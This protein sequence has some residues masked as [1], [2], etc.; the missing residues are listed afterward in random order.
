MLR[1]AEPDPRR[2]SS[3]DS[4]SFQSRPAAARPAT[5]SA[6]KP[7]ALLA[8]PAAAGK[9]PT[10]ATLTCPKPFGV[11][12][13]TRAMVASTRS[14]S[15]PT[16]A[17]PFNSTCSLFAPNSTVVVTVSGAM[18]MD[19]LELCGSTSASSRLPQYLTRAMFGW[20]L[21]VALAFPLTA[22]AVLLLG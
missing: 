17:R 22:L 21:A 1:Q 20:A 2:A 12:E 16:A 19:R 3:E 6:A 18:V 4:R 9:F 15:I 7:A 13:R 11:D 10:D 5:E 14:R 8:S